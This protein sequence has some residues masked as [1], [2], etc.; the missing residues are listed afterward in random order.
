M[1]VEFAPPVQPSGSFNVQPAQSTDPLQTLAEM[2]QLRQQNLQT[3]QMQMDM[4]S[5]QGFMK[6]YLDANG[7]MDKAI[8]LAP[9]YGVLPKDIFSAQ[10]LALKTAQDRATLDKTKMESHDM[11]RDQVHAAY[12]PMFDE[13]DPTKQASLAAS[14]GNDLVTRGV[15]TPDKVFQYT[16]PQ[17]AQLYEARLNTDKWL[18]NQAALIGDKARQQTAETG[19]ERLAAEKPGIATK[20]EEAARSNTASLLASATDPASYDAIRDKYI[21]EGGKDSGRNSVF[22]SSR[23][24]FDQ[25]SQWLPGMQG[26]VNRTGMTAEQRQKALVPTTEAELLQAAN[27]PSRTP[28]ERKSFNDALEQMQAQRRL[29]SGTPWNQFL[30]KYAQNLKNPDG[31]PKKPGDLSVGEFNA[32]QQEFKKY[33][34]DP[35]LEGL[36]VT[37][38]ETANQLN[39]MRLQSMPTPQDYADTAQQIHNKQMS[40]SQART[41]LTARGLSAAPV[42]REMRKLDPNFNWEEAE[43]TYQLAKSQGFQNT[44]RYMDSVNESIPLVIQRAQTLANGNVRGINALLNAGKDQVNNVDLKKFNTDRTL[45]A[46]E[47]AKILQGGGTGSGTSDM[48]LKQAGDI[49]GASDSPAAIAAALGDVQQLIGFRRKALTRGTYLENTPAAGGGGGGGGGQTYTRQMRNPKTGHVI[50]LGQDNQW[51]DVQ[52]GAVVK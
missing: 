25:N 29:E 38:M 6:A 4:Q 50:G 41:M 45:V 43:S 35:N 18:T 23:Q 33:N 1:P 44:V 27:D 39:L 19:A 47:I 24:V 13:K 26:L 2:G 36:R 5:Q 22:P 10:Q 28:A 42:E 48:K 7:D 20:N 14:I 12:Q 3:Q 51:H 37:Q 30:F 15:V 49:L 32:A 17:S 9:Q 31:T 40:P 52:T 11:W 8:Q 46:D 34:T 16:D 21:A